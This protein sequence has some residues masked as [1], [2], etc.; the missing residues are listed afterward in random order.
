VQSASNSR[1][2]RE[3]DLLVGTKLDL[4]A[5][6]MQHLMDIVDDV[7]AKGA[8]LRGSGKASRGQRRGEVHGRVRR[9]VAMAREVETLLTASV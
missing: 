1:H 2:L 9:A 8:S 3:G 6:S 7:K 4:L 5:C